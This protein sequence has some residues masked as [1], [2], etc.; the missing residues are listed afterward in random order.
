[1]M[2][3]YILFKNEHY[4]LISR[5]TAIRAKR[6]HSV[7]SAHRKSLF[8]FIFE[9][10]NCIEDMLNETQVLK[11]QT[12]TLIITSQCSILTFYYIFVVSQ[13]STNVEKISIKKNILQIIICLL[14]LQQWILFLLCL[15][16]SK[17]KTTEATIQYLLLHGSCTT[18]L[19]IFSSCSSVVTTSGKGG[20][21]REISK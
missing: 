12:Y 15:I 13:E 16:I 4:L 3:K 14:H 20:Y 21:V 9:D 6:R 2:L 17:I 7:F 10:G 8:S 1:M 19:Q 5:P 11:D 18:L